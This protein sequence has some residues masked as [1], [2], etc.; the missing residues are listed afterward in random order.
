[1]L[2]VHETGPKVALATL[3]VVESKIAP[4]PPTVTAVDSPEIDETAVHGEGPLEVEKGHKYTEAVA[5]LFFVK[6]FNPPAVQ[7]LFPFP[8]TTKGAAWGHTIDAPSLQTLAKSTSYSFH[9]S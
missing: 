5:I 2:I 7:L 1:L 4:L 6:T 8:I 3:I 9:I